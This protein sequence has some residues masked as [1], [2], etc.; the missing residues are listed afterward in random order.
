M[1]VATKRCPTMTDM[2]ERVARAICCPLQ[3]G[4]DES[5][6]CAEYSGSICGWAMHQK[7]ARA[8]I[9]VVRDNL[10]HGIS[11][12]ILDAALQEDKP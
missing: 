7:E 3:G 11:R 10:P 1:S 4:G 2:V 5:R 6:D 12:T 9:A 8:A